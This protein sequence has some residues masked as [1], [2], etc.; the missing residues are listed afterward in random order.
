MLL[1]Y[2]EDTDELKV[3]DRA[4]QLRQRVA[5]R[6]LH[7][8]VGTGVLDNDTLLSLKEKNRHE[9]RAEGKI[10]I[11][12]I[13]AEIK[14][15][16]ALVRAEQQLIAEGQVRTLARDLGR[17]SK[18]GKAR[19]DTLTDL[20]RRVLTMR[21]QLKGRTGES[22]DV[23]VDRELR[24]NDGLALDRKFAECMHCHRKILVELLA[25][26]QNMCNSNPRNNRQ[27]NAVVTAGSSSSGS[28][29]TGG[30]SKRV[31]LMDMDAA[32]A[33]IAKEEPLAPHGISNHRQDMQSLNK[34]YDVDYNLVTALATFPP[35]P[36]R[37]CR[38][39]SKGITFI[40]W[41]WEP[42][43]FNGGLEI[44][45]YEI[46][47]HGKFQEFNYEIHKWRKWEETIP[48]L[49]TSTWLFVDR[50]VC[51]TGFKITGLRGLSEYS[52]FK[53]RSYNLRGW[54]EWTDMLLDN[55]KV[56]QHDQL[57]ATVV[58][59]S[60]SSENKA[61][62]ANGKAGTQNIAS[63][64][65]KIV[66]DEPIP[67]TVTLFVN[68]D[69]ITSTCLHLSWSPPLFD[70]GLPITDYI[71][72]Y[73]VRERVITVMARDVIVDKQKSF[74]TGDGYHCNAI[75]RNLPDDTD[76]L[77]VSVAGVN[78]GRLVGAKG[79]MKQVLVRT[80]QCSRYTLLT[81]EFDIAVKTKDEFIDSAFYTVSIDLD[82]NLIS[83]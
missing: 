68:C 54:S 50:P 73:T 79:P 13:D 63:S 75:I 5:G 22:A 40:E 51:H 83:T 1:E 77:D 6:K 52:R 9:K 19:L 47:F 37:N 14:D 35:G 57:M 15:R 36:V 28:G 41:E 21:A 31:T 82:L 16:V 64:L 49:L 76:I 24:T 45:N 66:T 2:T 46:S 17:V 43:I 65:E 44:T 67:P 39:K 48:S 62:V 7:E 81:R 71:V 8:A 58:E 20:E 72:S 34:V 60:I 53:I 27:S 10:E 23:L 80:L 30:S 70:G 29:G 12:L 4:F 78:V 69:K 56:R 74:R 42:P 26:H 32:Q 61:L 11:Q 25:T 38:L 59:H 3:H 18:L 55:D 33:L